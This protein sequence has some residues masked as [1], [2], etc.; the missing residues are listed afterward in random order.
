MGVRFS[1]VAGPPRAI[2][3]DAGLILGM[4]ASIGIA[5]FRSV[6][7]DSM[8]RPTSPWLASICLGTLII[9]VAFY[10]WRTNNY[11]GMSVGPRW[12]IWLSPM[13][14]LS[15]QPVLNRPRPAHWSM[16]FF[17]RLCSWYRSARQAT[18]LPIRGLIPGY[19]IGFR[20][21]TGFTT[22]YY[23]YDVRWFIAPSRGPRCAGLIRLE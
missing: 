1:S 3:L 21:T 17:L 20:P 16:W 10:V 15:M 11:G 2:L 14:L 8:D 22:D 9:V 23:G 4:L 12:L 19:S 18:A 6:N 7:E 5:S 13:L